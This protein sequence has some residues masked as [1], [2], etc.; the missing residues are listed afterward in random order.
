LTFSAGA[1]VFVD[2]NVFL[3]H[4]GQDPQYGPPSTDLLLRIKRK[5]I[6]GFTSTHIIGEI[7]H[8]MMTIEA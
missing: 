6:A 8:R 5:Q 1:D 3:H 2:A 4:F 7:A